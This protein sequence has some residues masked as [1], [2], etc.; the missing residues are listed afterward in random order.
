MMSSNIADVR[1]GKQSLDRS[2]QNKIILKNKQIIPYDLSI[3]I[4]SSL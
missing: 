2:V 1:A 3:D 4:R